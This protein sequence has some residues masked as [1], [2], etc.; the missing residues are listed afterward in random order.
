M[1]APRV[2][3][4]YTGGRRLERLY[5]CCDGKVSQFPEEWIMSVVSA[6]NPGREGDPEDGM[7]HL[8]DYGGCTLK[9]LLELDPAYYLGE[10]HAKRYGAFPGVLVKLIDSSERLTVQ[11]HPDRERARRLF[12]SEYG[13]TEC[14]HILD[15]TPN[16]GIR[17]YVYLGFR[18]GIT[19]ERWKELFFRQDIDGMLASIHKMEVKKG[20]TILIP[21]GIPHAIGE[22]C[23][24]MEIQEP[25]DYTIRVERTTPKGLVIDDR[26]CHQGIGFEKM[27]DCFSYEGVTRKEALERWFVRPLVQLEK[28]E[29]R[30][31]RQNHKQ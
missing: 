2:W 13:K 4:T 1:D 20:D 21:G 5:G 31:E 30:V 8:P 14:W 27:F 6:R 25:T 17:P 15:D 3:R 10:K 23:F 16:Q 26:L 28:P 22:G 12:H 18:P 24:L 19:R 11:V 29:G 9:E 7:S